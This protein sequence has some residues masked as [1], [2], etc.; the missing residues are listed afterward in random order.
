MAPLR[1]LFC[2]LVFLPATLSAADLTT[3]DGKKLVGEITSI[4]PT[5]LTF[6]TAIKEEKFLLTAINSISVGAA[7]PLPPG[8]KFI[9]VELIDGSQFRC[10]SFEIKGEVVSM[11][12]LGSDR[13]IE[14]PLKSVFTMLRDAQDVKLEQDFRGLIR[15]RGKFDR[16]VS[17]KKDKKDNG[18]ETI[19]LDALEGTFGKGNVEKEDV[20][21]TM[22]GSDRPLNIKM[23]R[24][25]GMIFNQIP[26]GEVA[27][28]I[29][30]VIDADG[31]ALLAKGI[32]RTANGYSLTTVAN[33]TFDLPEKTVA[34]FDFAAGSVKYLSDLEHAA[35]EESGSNPEHYQRDLTLDKERIQLI[36]DP[37]TGKA[38]TFPKGLSIHA[39]TVIT[40]ELNGQYKTFRALA[41]VDA[42][43]GTPSAVRLT[44]DDGT[45]VLYK[46]VI[47]KGEKPT[48]LALSIQNVEKLKFTIESD[49]SILDFGNQVSLA[50]ARVLK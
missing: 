32:T 24:V 13:I 34:A 17:V 23:T 39:R 50:N 14:V 30:R 48:D 2:S 9:A 12:L 4:S 35:L 47:K 27:P 25:G 33:V 49:G 46:G 3:L 38:E 5:E 16:L 1:F 36:L 45:Q 26:S 21:F 37:S 41:G 40:Y 42:S 11:K 43:V 31:N 44:I 7:K 6:K 10:S 20:Q 18:T 19:R 15:S 29:C 28:A 22:E 8:S